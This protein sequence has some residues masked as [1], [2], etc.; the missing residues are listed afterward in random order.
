MTFVAGTRLGPYEILAPIGAGGMGEVYKA[1][2]TRL[3]RTVAVKVLPQHLSSPEVRQRF[4]RE[5]RTISQ[6]S[7]PHICALYDVGRE[8]DAEYLVMEYLEGEPLSER[9]LKGPLPLDQTLRYG[10]EIA[11]A[12]DKAHR[13]G[14]VHRDLKPGNVMLTKSGVKL[15]DF[16]LAKAMAPAKQFS[17]LSSLPTMAGKADNLTQEGTILGTLPYMA[18]EQVEGREADARTDIFALGATLYEMATGKRA[19]SGTTQASLISVILRDEP[20]PV[21]QILSTS[22]PALDRIIGTC[23]A[24]DPDHRWQSAADVGLQLAWIARGGT[25]QAPAPTRGISSSPRWLVG[26]AAAGVLA[27]VLFAA[28]YAFR[29]PSSPSAAPI[30][31]AVRAP[32]GTRFTW[33]PQHQSFSVSP[34]GRRLVFVARSADGRDFLWVRA[35]AGPSAV[36]LAGTEGAAAPF[37]SPDSRFVAFFADGKLKKIDASTGPPVTLCDVPSPNPSGSWGS[38]N[39]ILFASLSEPFMS[40]VAEG[41]G[42]PRVVLKADASRRERAVCWPSFLPDGRHFLYMGRSDAEKQTYLRLGSIE[43][44]KTDAL[45]SNGS[46][47]QYVP[48]DPK[49][50]AGSRSGYLLYARD[51]N[52]LAQPFDS[53]RLRFVGDPISTGQE[54]WQH[55][56][57]GTGLF[58]ASNDGILA[59]RGGR[60][61]ARLAWIDRAGRETASLGSPNVFESV[62]LSPDSRRVLVNRVNPRTGLKDLMVGD[63]SRGVLTRLD[64][65]A[66][67]DYVQPLW[68]PDGTRIAF[69]VGS[70]RHP[71]A[72][73]WLGLRGAGSPEP[74]LPAGGS[75][76]AEDW[77][78]D[79]H[80]LVYFDPRTNSGNGLWVLNVDGDRKS[81]KL[82]SETTRPPQAQFSPDGRWIAYCSPESGRSEVYLTSFPE[83]GE[84]VRVS[85]SGGERPRWRRDGRE[86][87]FI[88]ADNEMIATSVRLAGGVEVGEARPLFRIDPAGW[89]DYDVAP[90]GERFLALA[91]VP[92]QDADTIAVTVNWL[93]LLPR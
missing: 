11:D 19:F 41:G 39:S 40:L 84:R 8:G 65:D 74:I 90:D 66:A 22:P 71:P 53:R 76:R 1:R 32:V 80:F 49:A 58:S 2:D 68:S 79:G 26:L 93:S 69:G 31:F 62:R 33:I 5:A 10:I 56:L 92:I 35:L 36:T 6:L 81:R 43:D 7:H 59:S 75:Q 28:L 89:S 50:P 44:G 72:M 38:R 82:L 37:W 86:I 20:K 88:S 48:G 64:L 70:I 23:F 61:P 55:V 78:P 34:D 13:Q 4:E 17:E 18:P 57:I 25:D 54:I 16:G 14:I 91:N 42:V 46:R 15:L 51:G 30:R 27:A 60:S 47:A 83:P 73:Y 87:Y 85:V 63:L 3:D 24:K 77:S 21:S 29:R 67:D 52:L 9:L 12:L 45:L